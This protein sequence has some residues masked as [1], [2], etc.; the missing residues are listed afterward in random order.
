MVPVSSGVL[1]LEPI[2]VDYGGLSR[3][4]DSVKGEWDDGA[5]AGCKIMR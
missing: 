1:T 3:I 5:F 2:V 4:P